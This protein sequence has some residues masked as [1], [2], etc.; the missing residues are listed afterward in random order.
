RNGAGNPLTAGRERR[1]FHAPMPA[2][3]ATP[4]V[5]NPRRV[6]RRSSASTLRS[7]SA[8][9]AARAA[10]RA[11]SSTSAM[12]GTSPAGSDSGGSGLSSIIRSLPQLNPD[13]HGSE[14]VPSRAHDLCDVYDEEED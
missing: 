12:T 1:N 5:M 14:V 8:I 9:A 3:A 13:H 7:F 4:A 11:S 2:A 6:T 10:A